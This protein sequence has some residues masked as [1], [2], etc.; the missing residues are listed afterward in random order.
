[1]GRETAGWHQ[2][3]SATHRLS[4]VIAGVSAAV[5]IVSSSAHPALAQTDTTAP[6]DTMVD[7]MN[8][9]MVAMSL[10]LLFGVA[11]FAIVML[12]GTLVSL[13][14]LRKKNRADQAALETATRSLD[15]LQSLIETSGDGLMLVTDQGL[16]VL[17]CPTEQS[18]M[19][20]KAV[21]LQD[22][23]RWIEQDDNAELSQAIAQLRSHGQRF[24]L[25]VRT[26]SG[27]LIN[28]Q[29]RPIGSRLVMRLR[30]LSRLQRDF[31]DALHLCANLETESQHLK[32][33]LNAFDFPVWTA[34]GAGL[35]SWANDA[36]KT[37]SSKVLSSGIMSARA[38]VGDKAQW[39]R[40]DK[41]HNDGSRLAKAGL[42]AREAED[43]ADQIVHLCE[44]SPTGAV[45]TAGYATPIS[46]RAHYEVALQEAELSQGKMLNA[47][48]T[49]VCVFNAERHVT[50]YNSAFAD[51]FG[52]Q[53][54]VLDAR[55][56]ESTVLTYIKS[57]R[58]MPES[59][60][61]RGWRDKF[62][63]AYTA[64]EPLTDDWELHDGRFLRVITAPNGDGGAI[65]LFENETEKYELKSQYTALTQVRG[66]TLDALREG[67][68]VF[69]SNG[70]L[71]LVNPA[72]ASLWQLSSDEVKIGTHVKDI[73]A[74]IRDLARDRRIIDQLVGLVGSLG[75]RR[76]GI[77]SRLSLTDDRTVDLVSTPLP[78]GATMLT[79]NDVTDSLAI[80][81]TLRES[82]LALEEAARVKSTFIKH[83][84]YELRSPLTSIIG[85]AQLLDDGATGPL[86]ERQRDYLDYVMSSTKSLM[87]L[88]DDILDLTTVEAGILTLSLD[89]VEP[90]Q[91]VAD[92]AKGL[93]NRVLDTDITIETVLDPRVPELIVDETRMRQVIYN[94]LSNALASSKPG[95]AIRVKTRLDGD[96]AIV[97][98]IDGGRGMNAAQAKAAFEAFET[99][100]N[101]V[102]SGAGLGLT[103]SR[104]FVELHGGML[105][106]WSREGLG[107]VVTCIL[108]LR[109]PES[110]PMEQA[111]E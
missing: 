61:H 5:L 13:Y 6:L 7:E 77:I 50:F 35:V 46:P 100:N 16:S 73:T 3:R 108:P 71:Q 53:R 1:M 82:N 59:G 60:N 83:V 33:L 42:D 4:S 78:G 44:T 110:G 19:P 79:A 43:T 36:F 55:P 37:R 57:T 41:L 22:F 39:A 40:V 66:A 20:D 15:T 49:A 58:Q 111:A 105:D 54:R 24:D 38:V 109:P 84:S 72:F 92:A 14:R 93:E 26:Q 94:L 103:L 62:S 74:P 25:D 90:A 87:A 56:H 48:N 52:F 18:A 95:S 80:E 28:V 2:L 97:S 23:E 98:V 68:A 17:H 30:D 10:A 101:A 81:D 12:V 32:Q 51:L 34:D 102:G 106:L 75:Q 21:E 47:L 29:G 45:L 89:R 64:S 99:G 76:E 70:R 67:V 8:G 27:T 31:A 96:R 86:N 9:P 107:T 91:L 11:L 69:G 88:V 63:A 104:A 85:F 65:W